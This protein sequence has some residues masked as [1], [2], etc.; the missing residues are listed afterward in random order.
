MLF[1]A[2]FKKHF[3]SIVVVTIVGGE[4]RTKTTALQQVSDKLYHIAMYRVHLAM[5]GV[6]I[7]NV[8]DD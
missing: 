1:N 7:H 8:S 3:S 5:N 2:T 6:R 4:N